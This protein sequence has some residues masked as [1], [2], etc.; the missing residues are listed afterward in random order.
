MGIGYKSAGVYSTE[1]DLS[2]IVKANGD[3]VGAI[4]SASKKGPVNQRV[5][6]T[7]TKD[8]INTFGQPDYTYSY[9][10]Y[11][12]LF[13]L[14]EMS[15]LYF[16]RIAHDDAMYA[17]VFVN[18][19]GASPTFSSGVGIL[20]PDAVA[21]F[22][23]VADAIMMFYAIG[24]G[25]YANN[26]SVNIT[27]IDDTAKTFTV[28]VY[29]TVN[30]VTTLLERI[31]GCS[32]IAG[33]DGYG[34]NSYVVNRIEANS[35]YV[36][37]IDNTDVPE[38]TMPA[39]TVLSQVP[40]FAALSG[41][42]DGSAVTSSDI[43]TGW[44]LYANPDDVSINVLINAGYVADDDIV[45]Q[46]K[47][48]SIVEDRTDCIAIF[49]IP[50]DQV[51]M[52]TNQA[53]TWRNTTQNFNTSYGALYS[54]WLKVYDTFNDIQNLPIPPS[55][56]VAQ[57]IA[58]RSAAQD[59]WYPPAGENYGIIDC[60]SLPVLGVT[61]TY[62]QGYRDGLYEA[63]INPIR[64]IPGKGNAVIWG[65]KTEH[66]PASALDRV[67][68]RQLLIVIEKAIKIYL[69]GV[70]FEL[71]DQ[72]TRQ[73]VVS[74]ISQFMN[75][76]KGRNGVYD[77]T[78]ICDTSNNTPQVIDQNQLNV[79]LYVQPVRAAEFIQLQTIITR[80][81]VTVSEIQTNSVNL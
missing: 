20:D 18:T 24:P 48:K 68:V 76:V 80:T 29:Q 37:C 3:M 63:G 21:P 42:D 52:D 32:R 22:A 11:C 38:S 40:P 69:E 55:G 16:T 1:I 17:N 44:D 77:F 57:V 43:S 28:E 59:P 58:R 64:N 6:I 75:L 50:A 73:R 61:A 70:L 33:T 54:P 81:G 62:T 47:M 10:H 8:F 12:A 74:T 72:Y 4:V 53:T 39:V 7:N 26:L 79:D 13:A 51:A 15:S 71:N 2:Q 49:D 27:D 65:Q 66:S 41:G 67:N 30:S 46:T 56:G 60:A 78:V 35:R 5:L 25:E 31:K 34:K 14:E 45:V 19:S 23:S 9:G 36:R